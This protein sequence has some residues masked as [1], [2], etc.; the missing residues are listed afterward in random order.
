MFVCRRTSVNLICPKR[1]TISSDVRYITFKLVILSIM[2]TSSQWLICYWYTPS[3]FCVANTTTPINGKYVLFWKLLNWPFKCWCLYYLYVILSK[4]IYLNENCSLY[5]AL[6]DM[7][8]SICHWVNNAKAIKYQ[9]ISLHQY[10]PSNQVPEY[11]IASILPKQFST[12]LFHWVNTAQVIKYQ[13]SSLSQYSSSINYQIISLSQY[14]ANKY[15]H[16]DTF[17]VNIA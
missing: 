9:I 7:F 4:T 17:W 1:W 11:F 6:V 5:D 14:S 12:I 10:C 8:D 15:T 2:I 16:D 13:N 3:A